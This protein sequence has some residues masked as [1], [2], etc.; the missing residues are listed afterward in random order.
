[1]WIKIFAMWPFTARCRNCSTKVRLRIP[2]WQNVIFQIL[3]Q[4]AFWGILLVGIT[5]GND[6]LVVAAIAAALIAVVI[7]IIPGIFAGLEV[8]H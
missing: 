5:A 1:M 3:A 7:A 8:S 2:R 6:D 4:V